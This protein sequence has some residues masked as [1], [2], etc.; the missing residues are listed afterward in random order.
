MALIC[1]REITMEIVSE[2]V[3]LN[4]FGSPAQDYATVT[5]RNTIGT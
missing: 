2:I 5:Y 1:L 3:S 4:V